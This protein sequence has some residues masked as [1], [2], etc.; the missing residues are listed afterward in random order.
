LVCIAVPGKRAA[1]SVPDEILLAFVAS[2]V[3]LAANNV[4]FVFV[5]VV[6]TPPEEVVQSPFKA[7][8]CAACTGV[9]VPIKS[10]PAVAAMIWWLA[11]AFRTP[12]AGISAPF[13]CDTTGF[14]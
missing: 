5:Q 8:I 2:M 6:V 13:T 14:G 7:G 1:L 3:A 11:F 9:A 12:D 10:T 4:P